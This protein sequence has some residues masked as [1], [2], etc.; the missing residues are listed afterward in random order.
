MNDQDSNSTKSDSN[1]DFDRAASEQRVGLFTEFW[2]FLKD[3]KKWWLL[4]IVGCMAGL[5]ILLA[6]AAWGGGAALPFTYTFW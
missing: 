3:N 5:I 4:P 1:S 2:E 6:I